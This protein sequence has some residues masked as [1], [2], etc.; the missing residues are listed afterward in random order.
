MFELRGELRAGAEPNVFNVDGGA[1]LSLCRPY[2]GLYDPKRG[3]D[4]Y[5]FE[6]PTTPDYF[7]DHNVN[8]SGD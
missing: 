2:L 8:S 3:V 1:S 5:L 6:G 4:I 7:L